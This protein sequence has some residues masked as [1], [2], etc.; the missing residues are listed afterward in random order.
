VREYK[1]EERLT[2]RNRF[3]FFKITSLDKFKYPVII[4]SGERGLL[5]IDD[6]QIEVNKIDQFEKILDEFLDKDKR[7]SPIIITIEYNKW[8]SLLRKKINSLEISNLNTKKDKL[9][10]KLRQIFLQKTSEAEILNVLES[11]SK[12]AG[13]LIP[14]ELKGKIVEKAA[15]FPIII[16]IFM[17]SIK[18]KKSKEITE[19]DVE[20][21]DNDP[22]EYAAKK[23]ESYYL[24]EHWR[25]NRIGYRGEISKVLSLLNAILKLN[26]PLPLAFL[27]KNFLERILN[28]DENKILLYEILNINDI[29]N[30]INITTENNKLQVGMLFFQLDKYGFLKPMHDIVRG[31][32]NNLINKYKNIYHINVDDTE[33]IVDDF[34]ILFN[35]KIDKIFKGDEFKNGVDVLNAYYLLSLSIIK[36]N[37]DY[38]IKALEFASKLS[39]NIDLLSSQIIAILK[40]IEEHK[41]KS[42]QKSGIL[43]N[44][45]EKL[46]KTND[47]GDR[48]EIW[49]LCLDRFYEK[50]ISKEVL[51]KNKSY[52]IGLLSSENEDIRRL[53]WDDVSKLIESG[54]I[55]KEDAMNN[56]KYFI[57]LL[58]S[59]DHRIKI[60]ITLTIPGLIKCGIFTEEELKR[61]NEGL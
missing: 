47:Q 9:E 21:I 56:K 16:K 38:Q 7:T 4:E 41:L 44:L 11:L 34:N 59:K 48:L 46:L 6:S 15:G 35:Q 37:T 39:E 18:K 1:E 61:Y 20:D 29:R 51:A 33:K 58:S 27:D 23:L 19:S 30:L 36:D 17:E 57:E 55:S 43:E 10:K 32:I 50:A 22:T 26:K 31:G 13:I 53:A 60:A 49:D 2:H 45:I 5:F 24:L 54:I 40:N 25:G 42:V 52:F 3:A 14:K 12:S 8:E 28:Y